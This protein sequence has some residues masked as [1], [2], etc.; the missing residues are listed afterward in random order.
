[1][2]KVRFSV[3]E[4]EFCCVGKVRLVPHKGEVRCAQKPAHA[5]VRLAVPSGDGVAS[6]ASG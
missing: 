6:S 4:G 5:K 3:H 1:M 2:S